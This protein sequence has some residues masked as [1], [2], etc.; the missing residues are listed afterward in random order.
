MTAEESWDAF[1]PPG[2]RMRWCCAVHKSVPTILTLRE[3]TKDYDVNAIVFE[4]VRA[5]E[6]HARSDYEFIRDKAKNVNQVNVSPILSWG[7]AEVFI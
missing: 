3:L 2:R 7:T 6:S 1:G 4:G 5:E